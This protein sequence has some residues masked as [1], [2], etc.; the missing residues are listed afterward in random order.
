MKREIATA[1]A[2]SLALLILLNIS[3]QPPQNATPAPQSHALPVVKLSE[4][5][6]LSPT[7]FYAVPAVLATPVAA[8]P[9]SASAGAA[10]RVAAATNLQVAGVDEEDYVKFDGENLYVAAAGRVYVVGPDLAVKASAS[11]PSYDCVVFVWGGRLLTYGM[12]KFGFVKAYLYRL[13]DMAKVAE[14]NFSGVPIAARTAGGYVYIVAAATPPDVVINGA[15]VDEAPLLSLDT[16]PAVLIV[17][18]VDMEKGRLNAS[19]FVSG[20]AARIYM[21]DGRLYIAATHG[22]PQLLYKAA[23]KAWDRLPPDAKAKLDP[24]NPLTLYKSLQDLLKARGYADDIIEALNSANVTTATGIYIF[25][26]DGLNIRLRATAEVPGRLLDQFAIEELDGHLVVATTVAPVKFQT[27]RYA[28]IQPLP[29]GEAVVISQD[30]RPVATIP[31]PPPPAPP[32]AIYAT[33]GE[34]SNSVYVLT[35]DGRIAGALEGLA[36]GERI[37]AARLLGETLYLVTFRQVDPLFAIDLTNPAAPR[38]LG[39]L[40]IPG[41]SEYLHPV[42]ADRLLGVGAYERGLKIALFDISNPAQPREVSNI[43]ATGLHSP[44]F[45]DHHA[46]AYSPELR[47]AMVPA[48]SWYGAGYALAV[49]VRDKLALR[50]V[51]NATADRAFF[52]RDAIYLVGRSGLAGGIQI[53]KY[54]TDLRLVAEARLS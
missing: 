44:V 26:L 30:G 38:V 23:V 36:P 6:R 35:P 10:T 1:V 25:D 52:G 39:L 53:W 11:C 37:Y 21:K 33:E 29:R 16:P 41:F 50:A 20:P 42:D 45:Y 49:E 12:E 48:A 24:A 9:L 17:A 28:I 14:F 40:K 47:L 31:P 34:P 19:A 15:R 8:V 54:T 13:P 5:E 51:V 7:H 22:I 2:A 46:F 18:A 3:P 43:T 32:P 27:T 4:L